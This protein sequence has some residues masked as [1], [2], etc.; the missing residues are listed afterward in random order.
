M[1]I[2]PLI[3]E[4]ANKE[5]V[6]KLYKVYKTLNQMMLDRGYDI[7]IIKNYEEWFQEVK[8]KAEMSGLFAKKINDNDVK[9]IYYHYIP[10]EK[11][12]ADSIKNFIQRIKDTKSESGIIIIS[13]K[14]SPQANIKIQ[15]ANTELPIDI[16]TVNDLVVNITEHELVPKHELLPQEEKKKLLDRYKI[17]ENQ[18]PKILTTDPVAKYLGLKKGDVVKITRVSETAGRYITYRIAC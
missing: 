10:S 2:E 3:I 11:I 7:E 13:G 18:L 5:L 8:N 1:S 4:D 12:N 6:L 17:K 14:I 16:F 9:R 15:D